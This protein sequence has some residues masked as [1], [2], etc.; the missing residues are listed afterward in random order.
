MR[1]LLLISLL[2]HFSFNSYSQN[3]FEFGQVRFKDGT[4]KNGRIKFLTGASSIFGSPSGKV[5]FKES[6]SSKI[7]KFSTADLSGFKIGNSAFAIVKNI[8]A[9]DLTPKFKEDFAQ[10][11]L[12]GQ[13]NLYHHRFSSSNS[14]GAVYYI[15]NWVLQ[16]G[17]TDEFVTI[18]GFQTNGDKLLL[19]IRD[20][21]ELHDHVKSL[22]TKDWNIIKIIEAYNSNR[23][24]F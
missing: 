18:R 16:K 10:V 22:K 3:G 11:V 20:N 17:T 23:S 5:R 12:A 21:I 6:G 4:I 9:L 19:L 24:S 7:E 1:N 8:E 14:G 2:L 15:D 13:I